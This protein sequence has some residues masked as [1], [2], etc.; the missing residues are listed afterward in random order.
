MRWRNTISGWSTGRFHVDTADM[1]FHTPFKAE[2]APGIARE[3]LEVVA[4]DKGA[5]LF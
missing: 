3:N 2:H 4:Q 5:S 1:G